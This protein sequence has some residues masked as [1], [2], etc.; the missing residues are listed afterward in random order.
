VLN[1]QQV[2]EEIREEVK[3]FLKFNEYK[4]T[5]YQYLWVTAKAVLRGSL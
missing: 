1:D 2:I 4:N 3:K 5:T